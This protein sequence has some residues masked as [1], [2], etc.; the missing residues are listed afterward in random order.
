LSRGGFI[1]LHFAAADSRV[2][3][4]AAF[5]PV[6]DLVVLNE[7]KNKMASKA[8]ALTAIA[9][10]LTRIP[11]W[12][13]I[14]NNDVRVGTDQAIALTRRVVEAASLQ[15][16]PAEVELHVVPADIGS[17]LNGHTVAPGAYEEAANWILIQT[18]KGKRK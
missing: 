17:A 9:D 10:K 15:G 11:L 3:W 6:T 16:K 13:W 5:A 18:R 4:V 8:L 12:L 14:G 7:F 1:A 2:R